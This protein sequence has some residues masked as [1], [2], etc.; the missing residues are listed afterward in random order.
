MRSKRRI[1][2]K[3]KTLKKRTLKFRGGN[4]DDPD[5]KDFMNSKIEA[6]EQKITELENNIP[7]QIG[8]KGF[9]S[10]AGGMIPIWVNK[11]INIDNFLTIV[12]ANRL[13]LF[14]DAV[15]A[16]PNVRG[17]N[18]DSFKHKIPLQ[19]KIENGNDEELVKSANLDALDEKYP[20]LFAR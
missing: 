6:L 15:Y 9:F 12:D 14:L 11:N 2:R 4:L 16:L 20:G 3:R 10:N 1:G 5:T 19:L 18:N 8:Y 17:L 7:V 13:V